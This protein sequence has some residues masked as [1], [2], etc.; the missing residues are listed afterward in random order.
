MITFCTLIGV[1]G[2]KSTTCRIDMRSGPSCMHVIPQSEKTTGI[3]VNISPLMWMG[4]QVYPGV[5]EACSMI[6]TYQPSI[7]PNTD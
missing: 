5:P 3:H 6:V 1:L 7:E 4:E 2:D